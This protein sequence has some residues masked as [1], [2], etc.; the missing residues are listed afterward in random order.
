MT[1]ITLIVGIIGIINVGQAERFLRFK[2]GERPRHTGEIVKYDFNET[3]IDETWGVL[4]ATCL[5]YI[6]N[7]NFGYEFSFWEFFSL[8]IVALACFRIFDI[9][10]PGP[11]KWIEN[12]GNLESSIIIMIDD[13]V[14]G[15]FAIPFV[16]IAILVVY[17][18]R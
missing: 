3:T 2:S 6:A 5:I 8:Q 18:L 14:A 12:K 16:A 13:F 1:I 7:D 9:W 11:I 17:L 15:V 10:K 4:V